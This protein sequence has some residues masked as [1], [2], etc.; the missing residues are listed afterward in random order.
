MIS[1]LVSKSGPVTK[2]GSLWTRLVPGSK[3]EMETKPPVTCHGEVTLSRPVSTIP[4]GFSHPETILIPSVTQ[5]GAKPCG[6]GG[7]GGRNGGAKIVPSS[8]E[9]CQE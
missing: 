2:N 8:A 5:Q 4:R 6:G 1:Q 7:E 3:G 9:Y